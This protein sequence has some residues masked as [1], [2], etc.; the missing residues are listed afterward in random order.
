CSAQLG[1]VMGMAGGQSWKVLAIWLAVIGGTMMSVGW[2]TARLLP[3]ARSP[4]LMELPPLRI[5]KLSNIFKKVR[6]RLKWYIKEVI[7]LFVFATFILFVLDKV[8]LLTWL[9]DLF[10]PVVVSFLGLP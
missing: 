3:G 9:E 7:P 1:A 6:A 5:P 10:S 8:K 2:A 4:F